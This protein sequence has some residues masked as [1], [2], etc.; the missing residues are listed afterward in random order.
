MSKKNVEN[1]NIDKEKLDKKVPL[2]K[3]NLPFYKD[4]IKSLKNEHFLKPTDVSKLISLKLKQHY[5]LVNEKKSD[6]TIDNKIS[7]IEN[8]F[9]TKYENKPKVYE[10]I[11]LLVNNYINKFLSLHISKITY[12]KGDMIKS[13]QRILSEV[14][15]FKRL[16]NDENNSLYQY[17]YCLNIIQKDELGKYIKK[18]LNIPM[19]FNQE[20]HKDFTQYNKVLS[21][22]NKI[23]SK[24]TKKKEKEDEKRALKLLDIVEKLKIEKDSNKIKKLLK[25]Q[26]RISILLNKNYEESC[27]IIRNEQDSKAENNIEK[28]QNYLVLN[29]TKISSKE[30]KEIQRKIEVLSLENLLQKEHT[31]TLNKKNRLQVSL[32]KETKKEVKENGKILGIDVGGGIKNALVLSDGKYFSFDFLKNIVEK[33]KIIDSLPSETHEEQI[34]KGQ[35]LSTLLRENVY[36]INLVVR[37]LLIYCE[38]N[39]FTEIVME[40]LDRWV[41]SDKQKNVKDKELEEKLN[42]VFTL[43]R[44][45][46]LT[47]LITKQALNKGILVHTIPAYYTSKRCSCCGHLPEK[48]EK[49]GRNGKVFHCPKCGFKENADVNAAKNLVILFQRFVKQVSKMNKN[50]FCFRAKKYLL[51][52]MVRSIYS[53]Q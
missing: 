52:E 49:H 21:E 20:Y 14:G 33:I 10:R 38:E 18:N 7:K 15:Y 29:K 45:A 24:K 31:I 34:I 6:K 19:A 8:Y 39:G 11:I 37:E 17:F 32:V 44:S 9:Q 48:W 30:F 23:L 2:E 42:R 4:K 51:S 40:E 26:E 41:F 47:E 3:R 50:T 5:L 1:F 36:N 22:G 53:T 16:I 25:E 12:T 43:L 35:K 27:E 13:E 28:L 46:G